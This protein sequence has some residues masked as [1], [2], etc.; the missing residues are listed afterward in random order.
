MY[1]KRESFH[2]LMNI[3]RDRN[4]NINAV[5]VIFAQKYPCRA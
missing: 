4:M 1:M 2:V 3:H 5:V